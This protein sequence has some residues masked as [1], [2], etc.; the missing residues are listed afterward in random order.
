MKTRRLQ[1]LWWDWLS[2]AER[3]ER[4]LNEQSI[5]LVG[6]DIH[7]VDKLQPEVD[8]LLMR[9]KNVDDQAVAVREDISRQL[10]VSSAIEEI[11]DQLSERESM[12]LMSITNKVKIVSRNISRQIEHNRKLATNEYDF[13]HG[14]VT[15]LV[16]AA[17]NSNR[18]MGMKTTTE[19][20]LDNIA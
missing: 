7:E 11:M 3:L 10:G 6:R 13:I 20:L 17:V 12:Q 15:Q 4:I 16:K 18:T 2:T 9:L 8:R 19:G 14:T 5:K 1:T